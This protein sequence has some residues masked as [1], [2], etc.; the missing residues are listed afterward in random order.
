MSGMPTRVLL[1]DPKQSHD[2]DE[3]ILPNEW[4]T[5][6]CQSL[7]WFNLIS[8]KYHHHMYETCHIL[9]CGLSLKWDFLEWLMR[10]GIQSQLRWSV[11]TS[12]R[13]TKMCLTEMTWECSH[14]SVSLNS[15]IKSL[16][17][18]HNTRRQTFHNWICSLT[19]LLT[20]NGD[21]FEKVILW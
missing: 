11:N 14:F 12:E 10:H 15:I 19:Y 6:P 18:K 4:R 9:S 8:L 7:I 3:S 5:L 21:H 13:E 16:K 20:L 2:D 1:I 17:A